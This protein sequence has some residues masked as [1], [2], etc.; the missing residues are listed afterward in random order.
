MLEEQNPTKE[1]FLSVLR[2][3]AWKSSARIIKIVRALLKVW[4]KVE[5]KI[6]R[7]SVQKWWVGSAIHLASKLLLFYLEKKNGF[8]YSYYS[9]YK[10]IISSVTVTG[11]NLHMIKDQEISIFII[12]YKNIFKDIAENYIGNRPNRV[13]H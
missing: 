6:C 4:E 2:L 1:I 9:G 12:V 5:K 3:W 11:N 8:I 7:N 10:C 13:Y